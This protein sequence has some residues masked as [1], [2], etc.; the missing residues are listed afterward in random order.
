MMAAAPF[1][2]LIVIL[3]IIISSF[4]LICMNYDKGGVCLQIIKK[5]GVFRT[6]LFLFRT[7]FQGHG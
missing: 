4:I 2:M 3:L 6:S 7:F 1:G 5:T